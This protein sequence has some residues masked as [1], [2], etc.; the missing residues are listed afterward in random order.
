MVW[1]LRIKLFFSIQYYEIS[2]CKRKTKKMP[3]RF[4]S[5]GKGMRE[6]SY[7]KYIGLGF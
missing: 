5:S 2:N 3:L 6:A 7:E 4:G 1:K